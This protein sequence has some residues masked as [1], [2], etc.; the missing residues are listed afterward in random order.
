MKLK[1][2][3]LWQPN[4]LYKSLILIG[5]A[6]LVTAVGYVH[7]LTG[8]A[9]EFH[10]FFIVPILG[11]SWFLGARFGYALALLAAIEW[12][13]ADQMLTGAQSSL[14]PLLFNT[15]IRLAIFA[16]GA[17]LVGS[18]R[19]TLLRESRLAREDALTKLPNR[20]EF[21]ERGHQAFAQA[22]RQWAPFAAVYID[23][24][25]FKEV[26]DTLGHE[27]GDRLLRSV[28]AAMRAHV[29]ASDVPGRLGG[30]EF[31]LL[32]PNMKTDTVQVYVEKLRL[33]LLD[34][35]QAERWPVTFSIGVASYRTTPPDFDA[36]L[37]QAD[38]L[39][40]EVKR[41]SRDSILL[42]ES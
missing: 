35:M 19:N 2:A 40:Y 21:L 16:G 7:T 1:E 8:L 36:L 4:W 12:F 14:L 42:R 25:R 13:L 5:G 9:Y 22:Q 23:L 18:I 28:A 15:V 39:M 29:R 11:V 30:D 26:N 10:A 3:F 20:R 33:A 38:E 17:W 6:L 32:L 37:K 34:A 31:A 24:D 27:I 41:G